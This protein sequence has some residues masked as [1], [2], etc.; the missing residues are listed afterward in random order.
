MDFLG[1]SA[2]D[3]ENVASLNRGFLALVPRAPRRCLGGLREDL[4]ARLRA[5]TAV[6]AERLAAAPFLLMSFR[7][8]DERLWEAA[9]ARQATPDLFATRAADDLAR[10]AAAGLGFLWQLARHNP[11][12][13]RLVCGAG[14]HWCERLTE[15]PFLHLFALAAGDEELLTVRA[16]QHSELWSKLLTDGSSHDAEVRRAAHITALQTVLT[17]AWLP[18]RAWP[19]AACATRVPSL[20]VADDG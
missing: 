11:F 1:P 14:V 8:R 6:Q 9:F 2:A 5:L 3:Y 15:L 16:G 20:Q 12:A 13:A 17:R 18:A 4:G 19:A 10:L 7:E